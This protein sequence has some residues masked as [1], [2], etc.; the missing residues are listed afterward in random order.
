[1]IASPYTTTVHVTLANGTI[2]S[3]NIPSEQTSVANHDTALSS[4]I[5]GITALGYKLI[6]APEGWGYYGLQNSRGVRRL[7]F[8]QPWTSAGLEPAGAKNSKFQTI[9]I[10]PNPC[11]QFVNIKLS[12]KINKACIVI[13]NTQGYIIQKTELNDN[14]K[15]S[16]DVSKYNPG[17]YY[18]RLVN[19]KFYSEAVKFIVR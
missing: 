11:D 18:I 2:T 8:A 6:Q 12:E 14:D 17:S 16:I 3:S 4:I 13:I 5:N 9:E 15:I 7:F 19:D 10:F 1:M